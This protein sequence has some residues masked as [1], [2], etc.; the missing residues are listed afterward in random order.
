M[1][2]SEM[3]EFDE[4][5]VTLSAPAGPKKYSYTVY[6][7]NYPEQIQRALERRGIW[8]PFDRKVIENKLL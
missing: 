2:N 7:G 5:K 3:K 8:K 6:G 1:H 4:K